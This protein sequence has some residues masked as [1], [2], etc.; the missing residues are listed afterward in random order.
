MGAW[1]TATQRA[2][3][4]ALVGLA[5]DHLS[6]CHLSFCHRSF[7][8]VN[9]TLA[10]VGE[11]NAGQ[12]AALAAAAACVSGDARAVVLIEG[13]SDRAAV[14]AAAAR[15]GRD[16]KAGHIAVV[17]MGGATNIGHF[18]GSLGPRGLGL[19]LAGLCDEAEEPVFRR[20]LRRAGLE[21]GN[22]REGLGGLGFHVCVADLE[23]E[24]IRALGPAA[25]ETVIEEQGDLRSLRR[26]QAMPAQRER[27][28]EAQLR[29]FLGT[30]S[31]RKIHYAAALVSALGVGG[32][33]A[34]LADLIGHLPP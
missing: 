6:S 26:F 4:S 24:L 31:G 34:P 15:T 21:A 7:W 19:R 20:G 13:L 22:G 11:V 5:A 29:R 10:C 28:V 3:N 8:R 18:A 32:L 16:L 30:R 14:L 25:V 23:D 17:A 27:P 9:G 12:Q 2:E 33:P 1:R